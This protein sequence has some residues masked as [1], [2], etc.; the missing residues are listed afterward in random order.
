MTR[1]WQVHGDQ[2]PYAHRVR[3]AGSL[4]HPASSCCVRQAQA[5]VSVSSWASPRPKSVW[6]MA[7]LQGPHLLP[8][9]LQGA[10][11]PSGT[12]WGTTEAPGSEEHPL[13]ETRT[14]ASLQGPVGRA[15]RKDLG[16][17]GEDSRGAVRQGLCPGSLSGFR[18]VL[19][20]RTR[21]SL[22]LPSSSVRV[23]VAPHL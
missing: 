7:P 12:G 9:L 4:S 20:A 11:R 8:R 15:S 10:S 22:P 3:G 5:G 6:Y 16:S 21:H 13:D 18:Y 23:T 19:P 17:H 14:P 1:F 2:G